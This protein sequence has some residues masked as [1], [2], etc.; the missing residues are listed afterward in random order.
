MTIG[1]ITPLIG[2]PA[3]AVLA[4]LIL[5]AI[6]VG[7]ATRLTSNVYL[8]PV[9]GLG[10]ATAVLTTVA[11]VLPLG[12]V[13][14]LVILVAAGLSLTWALR[15]R[16][17]TSTSWKDVI[18]STTAVVGGLLLAVAPALGQRSYGPVNLHFNDSWFYAS[19]DWFLQSN[20]IGADIAVPIET[21]PL[22][23]VS[24]VETF[25]TRIGIDAWQAAFAATVRLDPVL[26]QSAAQ[27]T[28]VRLSL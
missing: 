25:H 27:A 24:F 12:T 15:H 7:P 13:G 14:P 18:G 26:I 28:T 3:L 2:V 8:S 16:Q 9:L 20:R 4:L 17:T 11:H 23:V 19:L 6:G 1:L 10:I 22:A 5:T 21:P